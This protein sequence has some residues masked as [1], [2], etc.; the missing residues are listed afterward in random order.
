MALIGK[1]RSNS[2]LLVV[3]IGLGLGGFILMDMMS[4]GPSG[5]SGGQT[6]LAEIDGRKIEYKEFS[7]TFDILN[8]GASQSNVY[9]RR[10]ALWNFYVDE[11]ILQNEA[12][13]LG[14][15]VGKGEVSDLFFSRDPS[16]LS[17]Y[18][19]QRYSNPQTRQ[20]DFQQLDQ[21]KSWIE[22]RQIDD[23]IKQGQLRP[24]FRYYWQ[25]EQSQVILS[26]LQSKLTGLASKGMYTPNWMAEMLATDNNA[27]V[28]IA[29]VQIPF[30]AI[31][32][33]DVALSDEDYSK[34]LNENKGLYTTDEET[35]KVEYVTFPV[36][37]STEDIEGIKT[38]LAGQ[39][40]NFQNTD[41]DSTFVQNNLG[42]ISQFWVKADGLNAEISDT[43][44]SMPIGSVF[45][46]YEEN[47]AFRAVKLLDRQMMQ[48]SADSRHILVS[49][50]TPADFP[51]ASSK[52]DSLINLLNNGESFDSLTVKFSDD[53]GSK[54]KGGEYDYVGVNTMVPEYND[55]I[56]FGNPGVFQK[57][58][59]QFGYHIVEAQGQKGN[60]TPYVRV[61]Y[62]SQ[63]IIPS[64]KTQDEVREKALDF[65]EANRTIDAMFKAAADQNLTV[66]TSPAVKRNDYSV[67]SLGAENGSRDIIRW[68][69]NNDINTPTA[70]VGDVSPDVYTFSDPVN[71]YT[72]KIV[73]TALQSVRPAGIPT[74]A[75]V[76]DQIELEVIKMK[77]GEIIAA[78]IGSSTDLNSIAAQFEEVKVD[79]AQAVNFGTANIPSVGAEPDVVAAAINQGVN[80]VSSP[81]IGASG[82]F[83]VKPT[84]KPDPTPG[85]L[86]AAKT[87]NQTSARNA[88]RGTLMPALRKSTE[89]D[90]NRAKFY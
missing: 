76:K 82:V 21:I 11:T 78:K 88:V 3:M 54:N 83:V 80:S 1:I 49:A 47:G 87:S 19:Q 57:V 43:V 32:D 42:S 60:A 9:G 41:D 53:P 70:K 14:L 17:P 75:D 74:V 45:G 16:K 55:A 58:R 18:I 29:Y 5:F 65:V 66:E 69:F 35:R 23:L 46:P 59:T 81:V 56:F 26:R 90:D 2:W 89:I 64:Q 38:T 31:D 37:A 7:R 20:V 36:E 71:F 85:N 63:P 51:R 13:A 40:P 22:N 34:Y 33:G 4:S 61:A 68:A 27:T 77:K 15:G 39:V 84:Y 6:T 12:D 62:I 72:N 79:T 67:G 86:I 48:D 10:A 44:F 73:V 24:D 28:D 30:D 25:Q 50:T 8:S 52:A